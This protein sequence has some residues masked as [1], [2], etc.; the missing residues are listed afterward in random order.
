MSVFSITLQVND[1]K[2]I[3]FARQSFDYYLRAEYLNEDNDVTV[4]QNILYDEVFYVC[5]EKIVTKVEIWD[6]NK[7]KRVAT[8]LIKKFDSNK[9]FTF[10]FQRL[11]LKVTV[12]KPDRTPSRTQADKDS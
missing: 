10:L 1:L 11:N 4:C 5:G 2:V 8:L 6:Y 3:N 7:S 9:K 12:E